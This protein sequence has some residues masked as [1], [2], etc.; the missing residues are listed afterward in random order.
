MTA[1]AVKPPP[2]TVAQ[3]AERLGVSDRQVY[4]WIKAGTLSH[5]RYP[6]RTGSPGE[7]RVEEDA[8]GAFLSAHRQEA[9]AS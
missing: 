9:R 5:V 2:L 7:L 8:I 4:H 1:R 6:T 3:A